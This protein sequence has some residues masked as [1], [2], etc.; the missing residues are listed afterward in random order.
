MLK[1][2]NRLTFTQQWI[3]ATLLAILPLVIAVMY[4]TGSLAQQAQSQRDMVVAIDQLNKLDAAIRG[5]VT[6]I[7][8]S[9]RQYILL[10]SPNFLDLFRQNVT[11]LKTLQLKLAGFLP[12]TNTANALLK[13]N[14]SIQA[15]LLSEDPESIQQES[16]FGALQ[17]S[18]TYVRSLNSEVNARVQEMLIE[19]DQQFENV[20]SHL[21]HIGI[22]MVPG[23]LLL[24]V[25]SSVAVIRPMQRLAHA[26]RELG[27]EHWQN[28]IHIDGP[29]DL[30]SLGASLEWTRQRLKASEKQKQAFL[31]HVTHELKTPL[32]AIM[33]AGSLLGDE[34]PGPANKAQKQ[35]LQILMGNADNLQVLIQQL[36]N[37]NTVAHGMLHAGSEVDVAAMCHKIWTK[38]QDSRPLSTCQWASSGP[39]MTVWSDPQALEM[40]LS[41]LL[42]N[43]HDFTGEAGAV[44]V[45]WG[46]EDAIWWLSVTDTGPG[47][48]EDE[49][50]NIFKPFYQGRARRQGPL[51]GTGLGLAIVQECVT[52]MKGAINLESGSGGSEFKLSFPLEEKR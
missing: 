12:N 43:A 27:H 38:L 45:N 1:L 8:R 36:L 39:Q 29:A 18:N 47:V 4:A 24:L 52:H 48:S 51:K 50:K 7:E 13:V 2:F 32:A 37:Y 41:N 21:M 15:Q 23:T 30:E 22:L 3:G 11:T 14:L 46:R 16:V 20:K 17:Q 28:P 5:Q 49:F 10:R 19:S 31:R 42:S 34:V 26:I 25:L 35:V 33:E 44:S 40:V 6:N 9:A